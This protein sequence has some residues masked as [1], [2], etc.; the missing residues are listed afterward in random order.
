MNF[1][2]TIRLRSSLVLLGFWLLTA[3]GWSCQVP[4]FRYALERWTAE[5][6]RLVI[7]HKN[8]LP[9][10]LQNELIALQEKIEAEN[11]TVNLGLEV[12]DINKVGEQAR[13][14]LP[15]FDAMRSD[16][17]MVLVSPNG[18]T[19]VHSSPL[20]SE[21]LKRVYASPAR[22]AWSEKIIS[23]ASVV[24]IIVPGEDK[25]EVDRARDLLQQ[26]LKR[27]EKELEIPEGVLR[28]EDLE[29]AG[30]DEVDMENVLRSSIPL[31]IEFPTLTLERNDPEERIFFSLITQG[32][33]EEMKRETLLVP[34]FGRG[35]ILQPLP[36]SRA[37]EAL[38]MQGCTYLCGA[39]SCT[40]KDNNP[41]IDLIIDQ[42]WQKHLSDGLI[43]VEKELPPLEGVGDLTEAKV[44][45]LAAADSG[46]GNA[47]ETLA[48]SD[49][50]KQ[51]GS[52]YLIYLGAGFVVLLVLGTVLVKRKSTV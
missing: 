37:S 15:D 9:E 5:P 27:A 13:W 22:D 52:S 29:Q 41:G 26:S 50:R 17:W 33:P 45:V 21:N 40:V 16:P 1:L 48:V 7:L 23:G 8:P 39:C 46:A 18:N 36:A 34:M 25:G 28:P 31:K 43:V 14:S 6:Y 44:G 49:K 11:P 12:V 51:S 47:G 3:V 2:R 20:T 38:I 19:V 32:M 35:R 30:K 10:V 24:W 42:N 4:V